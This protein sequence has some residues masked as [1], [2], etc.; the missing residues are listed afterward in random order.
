MIWKHKKYI[1]LNKKIKNFKKYFPAE[2]ANTTFTGEI[3]IE[4][5]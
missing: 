2:I 3:W 1:N 4:I 5:I